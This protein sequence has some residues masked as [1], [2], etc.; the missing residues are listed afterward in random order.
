MFTLRFKKMNVFEVNQYTEW[1]AVN[2]RGLPY[3]MICCDRVSR[4]DCPNLC[5][6]VSR[7]DCLHRLDLCNSTLWNWF[8]SAYYLILYSAHRWYCII[9]SYTLQHRIH[10]HNQQ[11]TFSIRTMYRNHTCLRFW[12]PYTPTLLKEENLQWET[13]LASVSRPRKDVYEMQEL[14]TIEES[15]EEDQESSTS[16]P[17]SGTVV[18]PSTTVEE[19]AVS[20]TIENLEVLSPSAPAMDARFQGS[21]SS[22][23]SSVTQPKGSGDCIGRRGISCRS[24]TCDI[25]EY[26]FEIFCYCL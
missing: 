19:N 17:N 4:C 7:C 5:D 12:S 2:R 14:F 24:M 20:D 10:L 22:D 25:I 6:R 23:S 18:L 1:A 3:R 13:L 16:S 26:L 15:P 8:P 21:P 11:S 9:L